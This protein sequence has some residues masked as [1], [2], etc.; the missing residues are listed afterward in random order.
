MS[1][2]IHD[3]RQVLNVNP[4]EGTG[5]GSTNASTSGRYTSGGTKSDSLFRPSVL[6]KRIGP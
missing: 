3:V 4:K 6:P 2:V 5:V 1:G